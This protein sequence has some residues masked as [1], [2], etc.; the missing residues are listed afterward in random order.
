MNLIKVT[1]VVSMFMSTITLFKRNIGCRELFQF[2]SLSEL[3][4]KDRIPDDDPPVY[5]AHLDEL[6][7]DPSQRFPDLF[8][9]QIPDWVIN[10]FL[11][12][13]NEE[14]GRMEEELI[15]LQNDLELKPRF[16]KSDQY[17]WLQ[18]EIS[19][20]YPALWKKVKM[21]VIAFPTSYLVERGFSAVAQ[22]LSK[23]RNR[24][25]ITERGD[26]RLRLSDFQPDVEKL[27]SLHQAHPSH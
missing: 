10:P 19:E 13:C 15:S 20:R 18:K 3:E 17:F 7:K 27:I 9:I 4:E 12:T 24:L 25:Q 26:L 8:S 2:P 21:L 5:C 23:Q 11:D 1:S 6:H 14:T 16:K 22:L